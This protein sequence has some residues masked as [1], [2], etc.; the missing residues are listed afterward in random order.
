[1]YRQS[2]ER[3][4]AQDVVTV[5]NA[6]KGEAQVKQPSENKLEQAKRVATPN[7]RNVVQKSSKPTFTRE[8]IRNMSASDFMAN[9]ALIDEAY[10]DGRVI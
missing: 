5:L 9:E 8:Q 3:G 2:I 6:F 7:P 1:M 4:T 10:R